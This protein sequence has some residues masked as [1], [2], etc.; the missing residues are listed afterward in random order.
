MLPAGNGAGDATTS[1][2]L[3]ILISRGVCELKFLD[4]K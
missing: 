3:P 2:P 1:P 4:K